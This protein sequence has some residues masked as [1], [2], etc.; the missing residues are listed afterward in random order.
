MDPIVK[1]VLCIT[2]VPLIAAVVFA[3]LAVSVS[4][5]FW[6]G[7]LVSLAPWMFCGYVWIRAS[8]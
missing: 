1:L 2:A 4:S 6:L 3:V 5:W 8:K 7:A